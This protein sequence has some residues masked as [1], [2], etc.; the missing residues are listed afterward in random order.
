MKARFLLFVC[1]IALFPMTAAAQTGAISGTVTRSDTGALLAGV[2]VQVTNGTSTASAVTN[3]SGV[4]TVAGLAPGTYFALT[5]G[6]SGFV[7]EIYDNIPCPAACFTFT[8]V[9]IGTPITVAAG[10]TTTGRDFALAPGGSIAG[11]ITDEAGMPLGGIFVSVYNSTGAYV[12]TSR[13]TEF[14]SGEYR[15][16]V[17]LRSGTYFALTSNL[18][19]YVNEIYAAIPCPRDCDHPE[20]AGTP[21]VVT[22]PALTAG[23]DFVLALG[24][25]L[26]GT[27]TDEG[28]GAPIQGVFV[29]ARNG[30]GDSL[31]HAVT[32]ASGHYRIDGLPAGTYYLSTSNE[33]GYLNELYDNV[34]CPGVCPT[35][36]GGT[37][38]AVG[39]GETVS[40]KDFA[41]TRGGRISGTI[42]AAGTSAPVTAAVRI[43]SATGAEV[44]MASANTTGVYATDT[45]LRPGTYYAVTH[46]TKGYI[47]EIY[48]DIP[49]GDKCDGPDAVVRGTPIVV[50][51]GA[52]VTGRDFRLSRAGAIAGKVTSA[53]T[54]AG[55]R[56]VTVRA[57]GR[58]EAFG[59]AETDI[60]GDYAIVGLPAGPYVLLINNAFEQQFIPEIYD[61]IPCFVEC[62]EETARLTGAVVTVALDTTAS[63]IDF[64]LESG[65]SMLGTVVDAATGT[66]LAGVAVHVANQS[67]DAITSAAADV[68]DASGVFSLAGLPAGAYYVFTR[69]SAGFIDEAFGN[70]PCLGECPAV[71]VLG[72]PV[73][74]AADTQTTAVDFALEAGGRISGVVTDAGTGALVPGAAVAIVEAGGRM[75]DFVRTGATGSYLTPSGLA[76]G[77]YYVSVRGEQGYRGQAYGNV[78]CPGECLSP[79]AVALGTPI[80]V[81]AGATA[82]GR[83]LALERG[84]RIAGLVSEAG[85]GLAVPAESVRFYDRDGRLAAIA[86]VNSSGEYVT[87][88]GLAAGAYFGLTASETH[89]NEIYEDIPC[90]AGCAASR[91]PGGTPIEIAEG[92]PTVT[93]DFALSP[94]AGVPGPPTRVRFLADRQGI[95]VEWDEPVTGGVATAYQLEAGLAPGTTAVSLPADQPWHVIVGAPAGRFFIRV[96]GVN[97]SGAGLASADV[98]LVIGAG[99]ALPAPPRSV[100]AWMAGSRLIMT[101]GDPAAGGVPTHFVVEA[102][103][104]AGVAN[105]ATIPVASRAFTYDP[106]PA[107][108][109]FLRVRAA[110]ATGVSAP[111]NEVMVVAGGAGSPPA[112]PV[113]VGAAANGSTVTLTW[114]APAGA[115]EGY[116]IEA[117]SAT[118]LSNLAVVPIGPQTTVGFEGIPPGTY[119]VRLRAVNGYGRSVVSEEMV[120]VVG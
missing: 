115:V 100:Q 58:G 8:A 66:P 107:G 24:A 102:G 95:L 61:N 67:A 79:A 38:V 27:I 2:R 109:Y 91:A 93:R 70:I 13:Q 75:V 12:A 52:T 76:A 51:A 64:A 47:D 104:A 89:V 74:I 59:S 78:P 71:A 25:A 106:V 111:S 53:A 94:R 101:W 116:L 82:S 84:A 29:Y 1:A 118:G 17:G 110:N 44:S 62:S 45:G 30:A 120:I 40:G 14:G 60:K 37:P 88:Q 65:G 35:V 92:A 48:D 98:P 99:G 21:I 22:A 56:R 50:T 83:N 81:D 73:A 68:S 114:T 41:L 97:A 7:G 5:E 23:V 9:E 4:Y 20:E 39:A 87:E 10:T 3:G 90:P 28:T 42:L 32:D 36:A 16:P 18:D 113:Q 103:T 96:R 117:G 85:S 6:A 11:L 33:D 112:A 69:N 63:G 57:Y 86:S 46:N 34:V 72:V 49:C 77:T 105:I 43:Y 26:T 31:S 54:G 15:I 19:G 108:F 55:V 80:V 119:Y